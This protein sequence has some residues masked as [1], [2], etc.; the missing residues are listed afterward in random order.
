[1]SSVVTSVLQTSQPVGVLARNGLTAL[2]ILHVGHDSD[3][4]GSGT[5]GTQVDSRGQ[6]SEVSTPTALR[7]RAGSQA[8]GDFFLIIFNVARLPKR[9]RLTF[10]TRFVR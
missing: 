4:E 8:T 10:R 5:Q 6:C 2:H 7:G 3:K 9:A 1:M